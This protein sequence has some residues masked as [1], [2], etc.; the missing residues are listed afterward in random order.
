VKLKSG[1]GYT[2]TVVSNSSEIFAGYPFGVAI[3]VDIQRAR[4]LQET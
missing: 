4:T 3:L 1:E 2:F